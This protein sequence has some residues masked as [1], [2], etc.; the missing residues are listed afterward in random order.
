MGYRRRGWWRREKYNILPM[1]SPCPI[2]KAMMFS[3]IGGKSALRRMKCSFCG[4]EEFHLVHYVTDEEHAA[5]AEASRWV[6]VFIV[7]KTGRPTAAELVCL[8]H[9]V[10]AWRDKP[11]VEVRDMLDDSVR[12]CL[13]EFELWN[14]RDMQ[15]KAQKLGVTIEW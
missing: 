1:P 9:V 4:H 8:R 15:K 13:G 10:T 11:L 12:H 5:A 7:W 3:E 6:T 2:C 14:A